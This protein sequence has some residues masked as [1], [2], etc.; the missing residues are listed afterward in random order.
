MLLIMRVKP[1]TPT[2]LSIFE[3][4]QGTLIRLSIPLTG[5][6]VKKI[7]QTN[8]CGNFHTENYTSQSF[9]I[10]NRIFCNL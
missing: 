2:K 5:V 10:V 1:H 6:L 4:F 8:S 7:L 9:E 3:F